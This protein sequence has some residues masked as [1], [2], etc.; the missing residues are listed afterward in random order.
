[1]RI[2]RLEFDKKSDNDGD[3]EIVWDGGDGE[4]YTFID[5][6]QALRIIEHLSEVFDL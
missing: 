2:E 6:T 5:K 3:L 4:E 1:M